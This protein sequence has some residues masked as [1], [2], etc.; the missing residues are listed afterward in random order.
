MFDGYLVS[1]AQNREDIILDGFFKNENQG[2]YVDIGAY[3]PD[4]DS[5]T[6]YFY[7]KGWRGINIEP[8]QERLDLFLSKRPDD[9]NICA[10]ISN[11]NTKLST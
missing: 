3:D 4:I 6:R 1:Y 5:V 9:L 7:N 10:G 11:K 8:Q 2:F